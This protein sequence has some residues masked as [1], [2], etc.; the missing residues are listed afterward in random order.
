MGLVCG[1]VQVVWTCMEPEQVM[2]RP[3]S[4]LTRDLGYNAGKVS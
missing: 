1:F 3:Y 4:S 2:E